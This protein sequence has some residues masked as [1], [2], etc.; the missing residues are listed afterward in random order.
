MRDEDINMIII[1]AGYTGQHNSSIT[2]SIVPGLGVSVD[3]IP[4]DISDDLCALYERTL[5]SVS[6]YPIEKEPG[7]VLEVVSGNIELR[8]SDDGSIIGYIDSS[9]GPIIFDKEYGISTSNKYYYDGNNEML[10]NIGVT[11]DS[12]SI[13]AHPISGKPTLYV[14]FMFYAILCESF[15]EL[16]AGYTYTDSTVTL[17]INTDSGL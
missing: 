11:S 16:M 8:N 5:Y 7:L 10:T 17:Q 13:Q 14:S 2:Y 9:I 15:D 4:P 3:P 12:L 1:P 6:T